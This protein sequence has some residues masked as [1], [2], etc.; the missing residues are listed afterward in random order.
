MTIDDYTEA[1]RYDWDQADSRQYCEHG[2][3]IG[4]AW[5]PDLMCSKCEMGW[6]LE[7]DLAEAQAQNVR[8]AGSVK[9][10]EQAMLAILGALGPY[11][12][13]PE[14]LTATL[15]AYNDLQDRLRQA[16]NRA[17]TAIAQVRRRIAAAAAEAAED[18]GID[19]DL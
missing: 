9:G 3:F 16:Q 11:G 5:G 1:D 13:A 18:P 2:T 4:S 15:T 6:T 7:D 17:A 19:W 12:V 10:A 14:A 8:L